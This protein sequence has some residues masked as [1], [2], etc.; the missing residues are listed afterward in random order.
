MSSPDNT[1]LRT[2]RSDSERRQP[3]TRTSAV[4]GRGHP[5]RR[6]E[7][8]RQINTLNWGLTAKPLLDWCLHLTDTIVDG[9][10]DLLVGPYRRSRGADE[11]DGLA[12][13]VVFGSGM[14]QLAPHLSST[15]R[16]RCTRGDCPRAG[17][18]ACPARGCQ[19][20]S[21]RPNAICATRRALRAVR[22]CAKATEGSASL[23]AER[24]SPIEGGDI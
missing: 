11:G 22:L 5:P 8:R 10:D 24:C 2:E 9:G 3:R 17:G 6:P 19:T 7:A 20:L 15:P 13:G 14:T 23:F 16:S 12:R 1:A 21:D 4:S 18:A